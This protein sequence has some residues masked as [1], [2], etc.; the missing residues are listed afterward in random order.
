METQSNKAAIENAFCRFFSK[1]GRIVGAEANY[2]AMLASELERE[3]PGRVRRERRLASKGRS[4]VDVT[5]LD[6]SGAVEY[7]FEL[8][9]GA[10]NSRNALQDVFGPTGNCK[11]IQ[12]LA[13]LSIAPEKRWLVAV[14]AIELGRSLGYRQQINAVHAAAPYRV[15]FAY[16]GHGDDSF[17]IADSGSEVR[18]PSVSCEDRVTGREVDLVS[19]LEGEPIEQALHRAADSVELEADLVTAIYRSLIEQGYSNNQVALETYFG[20]APG[21]MQQRPDLCLFEPSIDG[22]FNLYPGG[23]VSKSY[24]TLKLATLRLMVEVKGGFPLLRRRDATLTQTY[25]GDIQKLG[26]W[27]KIVTQVA[28]QNG[29]QNVD[30]SYLVVGA[31]M[32]P[33]PL[34]LDAQQEITERASEQ[35][36]L[37]KYV[38]MPVSG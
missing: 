14:D 38:H 34:A 20:F 11:D 33:K 32:R 31:D 18:Y 15:G 24:D 4:G 25:L 3:F 5:V 12:K 26:R 17:L 6:D 27:Q 21:A 22:H 37:F 10:Y 30:V 9:G 8:K 28:K 7:A 19:L 35:G 2:Q 36:V 1:C 13:K 29:V 16:F 23:D